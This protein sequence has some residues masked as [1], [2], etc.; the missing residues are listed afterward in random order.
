MLES[1]PLWCYIIPYILHIYI[2]YNVTQKS[3]TKYNK[4]NLYDIIASN[5]PNLNKFS[6]CVNYLMLLMWIPF[7]KSFTISPLISLFK[8]VSVIFLLRSILVNVT[9]LPSCNSEKCTNYE[10]LYKYIFGHCNDKILSG[11][12]SIGILL[13][14]LMNKY[15]LV[16]YFWSNFYIVLL[17]IL[18]ILIVAVRW[19]YTIDVLFAYIITLFLIYLYP[20][21]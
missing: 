2:V 1:I 18:S 9:I 19:H 8:Y 21:L 17:F 15:E 4:Q 7:I 10:G 11:H 14:Y 20:D 13:L 5:T 16:N 12:I 6:E 3:M